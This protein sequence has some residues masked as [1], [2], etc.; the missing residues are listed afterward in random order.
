[1]SASTSPVN[2]LGVDHNR[3]IAERMAF[4]IRLI[5]E[6][7]EIDPQIRSGIPVLRGTRFP[8]SQVIAELASGRSV[9]EIAS[10]WDLDETLIRSFLDGLSIQLDRPIR[11]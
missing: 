5:G 7:V 10:E 8:A 11:P 3:A 1:M 6:S 9:A 2:D 4:A